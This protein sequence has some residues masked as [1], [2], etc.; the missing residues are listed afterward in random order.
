MRFRIGILASHPIQYQAPWFRALAEV[1]D[2]TVF[3]CHRPSRE[4][5]AN[6]GFAIGL[7]WDVD[8]LSGYTNRFLQNRAKQPSLLSFWGCDTPEI[9]PEII[10]GHFD[11]FIVNGWHYR[12]YWQAVRACRR[13]RVPV[14][15]RGDSHLY[16]PRS[17]LTRL[18]KAVLYPPLLR[19]FDGFLVV[20][21]RFREYLTH[22]GVPTWKMF[23]VPH[24]VD[25]TFFATRAAANADRISVL[26]SRWGATKGDIVAL[27][28]GKLQAC[29][30]PAD[31]LAAASRLKA[32]G[33]RIVSVFVGAGELGSA[34]QESARA[35][36]VPAFF[37]GFRNQSELPGIYRAGDVLV[38]P[39]E[40]ET[41]GLV[42]NEA[43]ACGVPAVVSEAVGCA[44][45]LIEDGITG[46]TFKTGD[47]DHLA[48]RLQ[49]LV[50]AKRRG[51]AFS[52][53]ALRKS[54]HFSVENAVRGTLS[55]IETLAGLKSP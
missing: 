11:G 27:F 29:K 24:C 8:L 2:L 9:A 40:S 42:V 20:G 39:S 5:Q 38:L 44:P 52:E 18:L 16:T 47:V 37:E 45:D 50:A 19:N 26:R 7:E 51:H 53:N 46:F 21:T 23:Y 10:R 15:V 34:L 31:L 3:Y 6:A 48:E 17:R 49:R 54:R 41:W 55:A 33:N 43:M 4:D 35:L 28:V 13:K 12:S 36:A 22:Y 30:R 32:C 25:N 14:F 1:T